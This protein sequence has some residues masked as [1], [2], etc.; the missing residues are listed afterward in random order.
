MKRK[1]CKICNTLFQPYTSLQKICRSYE[2]AV[3][4][5]QKG[6][7]KKDAIKRKQKEIN[8]RKKAFREKDIKWQKARAQKTFN[9]YIRK[10]DEYLGCISCGVREAG[11]W[12]AGHFK[13]TGAHPELRFD[14]DNCH[15]QCSVCNNYK[16]GNLI[17]YR[18]NLVKKIGKER[19][20]ALEKYR[21]P[22]KMTA[23]DYEKV[24]L[25]YQSKLKKLIE[26]SA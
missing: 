7:F 14:E 20:L 9:A 23:K 12:D 1:R 13:T 15:K 21:P 24:H 6:E 16:S 4:M 18:E 19:V 3:A 10:R 5:Q 11:Q 17:A 26:P 8:K 25:K 2:C 22:Q